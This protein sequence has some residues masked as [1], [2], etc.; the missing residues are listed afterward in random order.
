MKRERIKKLVHTTL[1]RYF[2]KHLQ[3]LMTTITEISITPR[4]DIVKVYVSFLSPKQDI[5]Q[6]KFLQESVIPHTWDIKKE[7]AYQ[8]KNAVRT[9]PKDIRFYVDS[10]PEKAAAMES[11]LRTLRN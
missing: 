6:E 1:S 5:D 2:Q 7:L 10:T 3:G 8:L 4:L 9:V 11:L